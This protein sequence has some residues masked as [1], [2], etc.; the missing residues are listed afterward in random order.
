MRKR[1]VIANSTLHTAQ[2][3]YYIFLSGLP[4]NMF[5]PYYP[6]IDRECCKSVGVAASLHVTTNVANT[7]L[8][9]SVSLPFSLLLDSLP[10]LCPVKQIDY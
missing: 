6:R 8:T 7:F 3:S 5:A 2:R 4:S 9:V 1:Q 10:A